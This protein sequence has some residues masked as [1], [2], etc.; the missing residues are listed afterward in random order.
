MPKLPDGDACLYDGVCENGKCRENRCCAD[1]DDEPEGVLATLV[2]DTLD[3]LVGDLVDFILKPLVEGT[4]QVIKEGILEQLEKVG[5]L[6]LVSEDADECS[7]IRNPIWDKEVFSTS[8]K[9]EKILSVHASV[10][11]NAC[12][13]I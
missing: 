3:T 6:C 7:A 10:E 12:I 8:Y 1:C 4:C 13:R 2:R 9:G 5:K 11:L